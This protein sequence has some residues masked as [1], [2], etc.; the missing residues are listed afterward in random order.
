MPVVLHAIFFRC[1]SMQ[2]KNKRL[3]VYS[4][5]ADYMIAL[6]CAQKLNADKVFTKQYLND[7]SKK[8]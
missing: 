6:N 4:D 2:L 1:F 3:P 8:K 5:Y 7:S